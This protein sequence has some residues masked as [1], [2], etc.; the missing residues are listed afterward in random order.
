LIFGGEYFCVKIV[1][2]MKT[3]EK[4]ME[5]LIQFATTFRGTPIQNEVIS[6][7]IS[8]LSEVN[9]CNDEEITRVQDAYRKQLV[10][11]YKT[12]DPNGKNMIRTAFVTHRKDL[13][14]LKSKLRHTPK[15]YFSNK[16]KPEKVQE[17]I[18]VIPHTWY[19]TVCTCFNENVDVCSVCDVPLVNKPPETI[20]FHFD[21]LGIDRY[22]D[23]EDSIDYGSYENFC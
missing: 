18:K 3:F 1:V 15:P 10:E 9:E 20:Y 5:E 19:C 21:N 2:A 14:K 16:N 23:K 8:E 22:S 6:N 11:V 12:S 17:I 13:K 4:I 7:Y